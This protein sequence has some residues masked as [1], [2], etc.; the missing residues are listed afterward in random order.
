MNKSKI[1]KHNLKNNSKIIKFNTR[2]TEIGYAKY[3]PSFSKEWKNTIYSFNKNITSNIPTFTE[4]INKIIKSYFNLYFKDRKFITMPKFILLKRRRNF[5]RRIF[6]SNAE[7][8]HTNNKIVITLYILNREK[9]ILK[10]KY[11]NMNNAIKRKLVKQFY[12]IYKK[13]IKM[14]NKLFIWF[15]ST[16]GNRYIPSVL[17]KNIFLKNKIQNLNKIRNIKLLFLGKIWSKLID[18]YL[19]LHLKKFRKYSLLYSLNTFKFNKLNMLTVLSN[20][21][22]KIR[23][24]KNK[25]IEY[26][27]VNLKYLTNNP[28]LFTNLIALKLKRFKR[29]QRLKQMAKVLNR[30]HLPIVNTIQERTYVKRG[31]D[32]Y[33]NKYKNLKIISYL[34]NRNLD[35][36]LN[37]F[38][39]KKT[40]NISN[41]IYNSIKYKNL[42]GIRIEVKGRLTKRY[43]ADRSIYSLRWKGGLKNIESSFQKIGTTLLRGNVKSNTAYSI[44]PSKRRIGAF[45]VKGWIAGK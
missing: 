37:S 41:D 29:I 40:K 24:L 26:N 1:F 44:S 30:T 2:K 28:E 33:K 15:N 11:I 36:F 20:I 42:G 39:N 38:G 25:K 18:R 7:I 17:R 5:L 19:D 21:L 4:T 8:K 23:I 31:L 35:K 27:I 43:R 14:T 6:T 22:N 12:A 32:V 9:N 10:N 16:H 34:K 3:L 13:N 45:A